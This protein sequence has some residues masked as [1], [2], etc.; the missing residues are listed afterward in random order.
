[1]WKKFLE[2]IGDI[3]KRLLDG[4][5]SIFSESSNVSCTRFCVVVIVLT[6][7]FNW[8]YQCIEQSKF[9]PLDLNNLIGLLGVLCIKIGQ[10]VVE[11]RTDNN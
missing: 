9:L 11:K 4:A 1:M 8:T 10:K 3:L 5:G 6:F 7:M 2:S